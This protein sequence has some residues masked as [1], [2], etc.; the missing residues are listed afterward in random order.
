[1]EKK[2]FFLAVDIGNSNIVFGIFEK[3]NVIS[4]CRISTS[5]DK[6][7]D[8]IGVLF[9]NF[10]RDEIKTNKILSEYKI[11][12]N[13]NRDIPVSDLFYGCAIAS[14]VPRMTDTVQTAIKKYLKLNSLIISPALNTGIELKVE[15]PDQVGADR[16]CNC[17]AAYKKCKDSTIIIDIGTA[18]TFDIVSRKGEFLG[19]IIQPGPGTMV[20]AL[21][22]KA[23]KLPPID[24]FFP[25]KV[26]GKNTVTNIQS[27]ILFGVVH[28][29]MGLIKQIEK[30][31]NEK[32]KIIIT[33]GYAERF[34][35]YI[36]IKHSL[37]PNLLLDGIRIIYDRNLK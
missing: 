35:P 22:L 16:I 26:I 32:C 3:D 21:E 10:L 27:G 17:V 33:G 29:T 9:L 28:S 12:K 13:L 2:D 24:L 37:E 8:E 19:G 11:S 18:L 23:A 5:L 6:T 20:R 7:S 14:V 31:L 4:E 36:T 34:S 25:E 30:E 15:Y 1:M